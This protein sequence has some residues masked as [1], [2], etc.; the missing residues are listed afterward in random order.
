MNETSNRWIERGAFVLRAGGQG[1]RLLAALLV[2]FF[3]L[4]LGL[5][6]AFG[7]A[8]PDGELVKLYAGII[9][10]AK[11]A[12][13]YSE[14]VPLLASVVIGVRLVLVAALLFAVGIVN[15]A[16]KLWRSVF[17]REV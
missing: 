2:G 9:A 12:A 16:A 6:T 11:G 10:G 5:E 14:A 13:H 17:V 3:G 1:V 15:E 8:M 4:A 7:L